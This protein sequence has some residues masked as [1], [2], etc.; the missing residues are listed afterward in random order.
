MAYFLVRMTL[1]RLTLVACATFLLSSC[2]SFEREWEQSVADYRSGAVAAPYGPWQ[3][4]WATQ[5]N[6]HNGT[7]RAIVKPS[8]KPGNYV[9]RYHATWGM[10]AR[11]TY[12][13]D[14]PGQKQGNAYVIEGKKD[15]GPFGNFGHKA[16]INGS[17]FRASYSNDD[18]DLGAFT[19]KRP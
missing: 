9:F 4:D 1:L 16:T 18:G 5:T 3:G 17:T 8:S 10:L 6:G 7:L 15:L 2:S 13:V 19:L 11:G 14:F 12:S